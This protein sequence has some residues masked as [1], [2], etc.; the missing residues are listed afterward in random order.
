MNRFKSILIAT[1]LTTAGFAGSAQAA[2]DDTQFQ[3]KI[4]ITESCDI[5]TV[6][7]TD[8]DFLSH[9][10]STGTPVDA[11]GKLVVN[12]STG[13]PFTIALDAGV[14]STSATASA[15]NR[16]MI[17]GSNYVPYGLYRDAGH[18]QFWGNAIGTDTFASTGTGANVDVPVF[19]R[20]PSTNFPAGTYLDTVTATIT[21]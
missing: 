19:G 6:S 1:A 20:V 12:C 18:T 13:T 10:R 8:I 16:R 7:A 17:N 5:S 4:V 9:T 21:Y 15:N 11:Q 3:V 2:T 14:N